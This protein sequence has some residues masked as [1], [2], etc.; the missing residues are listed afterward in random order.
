MENHELTVSELEEKISQLREEIEELEREN[1]KLEEEF[2]DLKKEN[3]QHSLEID[4]LFQN[5]SALSN[6]RET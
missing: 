3:R 1:A 2:E 4:R 6:R 5:I